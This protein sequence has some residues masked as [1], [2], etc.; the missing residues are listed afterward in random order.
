M[1]FVSIAVHAWGEPN[2]LTGALAG[3]LGIN[4]PQGYCCRV[5][6]KIPYFFDFIPGSHAPSSALASSHELRTASR[7]PK[8]SEHPTQRE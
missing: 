7:P 5:R 3:L 2:P 8:F 6:N 4:T 1:N